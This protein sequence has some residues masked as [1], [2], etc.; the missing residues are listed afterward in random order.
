MTEDGVVT[1]L[2]AARLKLGALAWGIVRDYHLT[3]DLLQ[4]L[5]V[6]ALARKE[7]FE[8]EDYLLAWARVSIRNASIDHC[9]QTKNRKNLLDQ[10]ALDAIVDHLESQ[11][12]PDPTGRMEALARCLDHLPE[13]TR[14]LMNARYHEGLSV[15]VIAQSL[16]RKIEAVYQTLSR[17]QRQLRSCVEKRT[18]PSS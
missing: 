2:F 7:Q 5:I 16:G 9:R 10:A 4:N 15:G 12:D 14:S 13:K 1:C 11:P 18:S 8:N 17:A 6:K 3:E